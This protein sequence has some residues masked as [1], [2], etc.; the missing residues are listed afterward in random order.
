MIGWESSMDPRYMDTLENNTFSNALLQ[1]KKNCEII[2]R[3]LEVSQFAKVRER[4]RMGGE[5]SL[6]YYNRKLI[7]LTLRFLWKSKDWTFGSGNSFDAEIC[8]MPTLYKL[9][10][11]KIFDD[12][13][14]R[15]GF[16]SLMFHEKV[17]YTSCH[18]KI[19]WSD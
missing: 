15:L 17:L 5:N 8:I 11:R 10:L 14:F 9:W 18:L 2:L 4:T 1:W 19:F 3:L 12:S 7:S 13:C 16:A 6:T